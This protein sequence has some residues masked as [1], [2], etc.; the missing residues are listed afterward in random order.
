[1]EPLCY[2]EVH[3]KRV[4]LV[5]NEVVGGVPVVFLDYGVDL[6]CLV[7]NS[8]EMVKAM[9]NVHVLA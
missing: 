8:E 5:V 2:D 6:N 4:V 9:R 7:V 3:E 1:M